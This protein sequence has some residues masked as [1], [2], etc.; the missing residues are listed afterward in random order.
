ML[1]CADTWDS[2][3][4]VEGETSPDQPRDVVSDE[5]FYVKELLTVTYGALLTVAE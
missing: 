3:H 5:H 4:E 1:P 2:S